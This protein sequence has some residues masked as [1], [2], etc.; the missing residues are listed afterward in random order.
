MKIQVKTSDLLQFPT[1]FSSINKFVGIK[2][3]YQ[4][5]FHI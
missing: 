5:K 2:T 3:F 4:R 1:K